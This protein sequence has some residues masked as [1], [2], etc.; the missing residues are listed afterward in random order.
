MTLKIGIHHRYGKKNIFS[1]S[2][3]NKLRHGSDSYYFLIF[4]KK[5]F[6]KKNI[7]IE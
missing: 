2:Q 7:H 5:F 6:Y 1:I 4:L 3:K